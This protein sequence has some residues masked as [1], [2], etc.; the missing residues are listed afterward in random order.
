MTTFKATL[1]AA[2][3]VALGATAL[4]STSAFA[5]VMVSPTS[6]GGKGNVSDSTPPP[7]TFQQIVGSGPVKLIPGPHAPLKIA[8][9][10]P[11]CHIYVCLHP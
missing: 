5:K 7:P 4:A 8:P 1:A 6:N 9:P 11:T 10:A 3:A 2:A